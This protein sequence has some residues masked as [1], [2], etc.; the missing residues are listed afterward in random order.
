M[1]YT[2]NFHL[3]KRD[4]VNIAITSS[5]LILF[6]LFGCTIRIYIMLSLSNLHQIKLLFKI[7][8][9]F[10]CYAETLVSGLNPD[11]K[12]NLNGHPSMS[13]NPDLN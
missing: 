4:K 6:S 1:Q 3:N 7:N 9:T 12:S 13:I 11:L 8:I 2:N 10:H 5:N